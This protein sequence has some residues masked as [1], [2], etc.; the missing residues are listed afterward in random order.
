MSK[1]I[2][3]T[4]TELE[5]LIAK[6][7]RSLDQLVGRVEHDGSCRLPPPSPEHFCGSFVAR[8]QG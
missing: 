3:L 8:R 6:S 5:H 7:V 1:T 2:T 4:Q